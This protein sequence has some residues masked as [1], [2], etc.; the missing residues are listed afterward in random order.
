V[1][2]WLIVHSDVIH[3][4]LHGQDMSMGALQELSL[5]TAIISKTALPGAATLQLFEML[6]KLIHD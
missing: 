1:L 5:L 2:Q 3:S 6:H 4:I